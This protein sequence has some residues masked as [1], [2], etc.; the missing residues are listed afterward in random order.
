MFLVEA[1]YLGGA[2]FY[3]RDSLLNRIREPETEP[4]NEHEHEHADI[5][6][7]GQNAPDIEHGRGDINASERTAGGNRETEPLLGSRM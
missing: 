7:Q 2:R 5:E 6:G 3:G 1:L 4:E